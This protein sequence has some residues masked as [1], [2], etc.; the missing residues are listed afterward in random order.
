MERDP[1][2]IWW[3]PM[4]ECLDG[5]LYQIVGRRARLGI[6]R[7]AEQTFT[8]LDHDYE[9]TSLFHEN[10]WDDNPSTGTAKPVRPLEPA[11]AGASAAEVIAFLEGAHR[12]YWNYTTERKDGLYVGVIYR[13]R[14]HVEVF[15][16]HDFGE[17][18]DR[19]RD[20]AAT[21]NTRIAEDRRRGPGGLNAED[22]NDGDAHR[23]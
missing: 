1:D 22:R 20:E 13:D 16:S 7:A 15:R 4:S 11:P 21:R 8:I 10:H 17:A 5:W 19:A 18:F 12:R 9:E 23:T 2:N 6:Y 14:E 3:I